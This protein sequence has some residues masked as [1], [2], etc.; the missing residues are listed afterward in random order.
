MPPLI[1]GEWGYSDQVW[2]QTTSGWY[3]YTGQIDRMTQ[4]KYLAR[5]WLTNALEGVPSIWCKFL[6]GTGQVTSSGDML[7]VVHAP[8]ETP[9]QPHAPKPAYVAATT[10]HTHLRG[11]VYRGRISANFAKPVADSPIHED[12]QPVDWRGRPLPTRSTDPE[13]GLGGHLAAAYQ[14]RMMDPDGISVMYV[15][16]AV[17]TCIFVALLSRG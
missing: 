17:R 5:M 14:Q 13:G 10:L 15:A 16:V 1:S 4:A 2:G 7:G 8:Y 3:P 9:A 6:S 11:G 12:E